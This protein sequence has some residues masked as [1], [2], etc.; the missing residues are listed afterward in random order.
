MIC[1][2]TRLQPNESGS[3]TCREILKILLVRAANYLITQA[4]IFEQEDEE[5][6]T[7]EVS[8]ANDEFLNDQMDFAAYV[9]KKGILAHELGQG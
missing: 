8:L 7:K 1:L 5:G 9:L 6:T 4:N 2:L 3:G